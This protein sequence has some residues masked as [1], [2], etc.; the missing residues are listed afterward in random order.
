[1]TVKE[2]LQSAGYPTDFVVLDFETY[3]DKEYSL[4]NMS[5]WEYVLDERY[6]TIGCGRAGHGT[7]ELIKRMR[8][9]ICISDNTKMLIVDAAQIEAR[10]AAWLAGQVNMLEAKLFLEDQGIKR[11][12]LYHDGNVFKVLTVGFL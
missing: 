11:D 3:F 12:I 9:L 4:S 7:H 1:M 5:Y 6:E 2:I 10:I 8:H